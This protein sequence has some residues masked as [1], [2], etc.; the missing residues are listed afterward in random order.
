[1]VINRESIDKFSQLVSKDSIRANDFNLNIPRYVDSSE[2][3]PNW[4]L[5]A[6]MLGVYLTMK[7]L[8]YSTIGKLFQ[9]C[10]TNCLLL[11]QRLIASWLS[12]NKSSM[13]LLRS[14]HKC[15]HL[16]TPIIKPLTVLID[17]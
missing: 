3:T 8:N 4:D 11:N 6:T 15:W 12:I 1:M 13:S 10:V 5:H 16:L 17:T 7:L 2:A 14:I 9:R